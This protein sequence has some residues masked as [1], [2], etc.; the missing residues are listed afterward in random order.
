MVDNPFMDSDELGEGGLLVL[1]D[2]E[3]SEVNNGDRFGGAGEQ[4]AEDR[5][6]VL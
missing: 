2:S 4:N 6:R 5:L 3:N 1:E